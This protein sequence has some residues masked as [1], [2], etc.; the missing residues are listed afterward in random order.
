MTH[1]YVLRCLTFY[2]TCKCTLSFLNSTQCPSLPT[3]NSASLY[4]EK[5]FSGNTFTY[6]CNSMSWI[7]EMQEGNLKL[8]GDFNPLDL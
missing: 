6:V 2:D 8:T 3:L 7:P 1:T 4:G 5:P